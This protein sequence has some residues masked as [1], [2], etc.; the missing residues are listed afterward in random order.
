[1]TVSRTFE[2]EFG[3]FIR[4]TG[5]R[6]G[7]PQGTPKLR[8]AEDARIRTR[9]SDSPS[10]WYQFMDRYSGGGR[11][12]V[13]VVIVAAQTRR[14]PTGNGGADGS[15]ARRR[16]TSWRIRLSRPG[17][18]PGGDRAARHRTAWS[19]SITDEY[20]LSW[21]RRIRSTRV[22]SV[23][24]AGGLGPQQP[25]GSAEHTDHATRGARNRQAAARQQVPIPPANN[26]SSAFLRPRASPG[27]AGARQHGGREAA[28]TIRR[29]HRIP[30]DDPGT[31]SRSDPAQRSAKNKARQAPR[32]R[33]AA[34]I[35]LGG[36]VSSGPARAA[37]RA[38]AR[39]RSQQ[40]GPSR[41]GTGHSAGKRQSVC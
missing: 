40:D 11:G 2:R 3:P 7:G 10:R 4:F 35:S 18:R 34:R 39:A 8:L 21:S 26:R 14:S 24:H 22:T 1:M 29:A 37:A 16:P 31:K 17:A 13:P 20:K 41:A 25:Q 23:N 15:R 6:S 28:R 9:R 19:A 33:P 12:P 27:G 32:E 36:P 38:A 30:A 5:V